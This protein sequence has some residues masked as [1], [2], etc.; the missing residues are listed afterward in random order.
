[1]RGNNTQNQSVGQAFDELLKK[2][3]EK[4]QKQSSAPDAEGSEASQ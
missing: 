3:D 2:M 1:V 4:V